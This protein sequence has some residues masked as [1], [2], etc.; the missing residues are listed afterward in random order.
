MK[1]A[2]LAIFHFC[3]YKTVEVSGFLTLSRLCLYTFQKLRVAVLSM[4]WYNGKQDMPGK[5]PWL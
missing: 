2:T 4:V 3:L 1:K 5:E